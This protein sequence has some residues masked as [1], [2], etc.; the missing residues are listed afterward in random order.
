VVARSVAFDF[1]AESTL[2]EAIETK[3]PLPNLYRYVPKLDAG[4]QERIEDR[5]KKALGRPASD[6]DSHPPPELRIQ[7]VNALAVPEPAG[8]NAGLAWDLFADREALEAQMTDVICRNVE[9][10]HGVRLAKA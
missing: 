1:H 2:K 6:T 10:K 7:W 3:A 4:T 8:E 9:A 5:T